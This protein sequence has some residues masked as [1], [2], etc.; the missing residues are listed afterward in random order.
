M[1][2]YGVGTA[3]SGTHSIAALF[4]TNYRARHEADHEE[5]IDV[6][7]R[8]Q[9]G[10]A[11][12]RQVLSELAERERCLSLDADVSQLNMFIVHEL[13]ALSPRARF[14]LTIRD[15]FSW[16]RSFLDHQLR[17]SVDPAW[18]RLRH[19]R[20]GPQRFAYSHHER[21]LEQHGLYAVHSYFRYWRRHNDEILGAVPADRLLV[22]RTSEISRRVGE[23]ARFIGVPVTALDAG[24]AHSFRSPAR[25]SVLA[26]V[27][28]NF[29]R[30]Q[31]LT[32][33]W[34]LMARFFPATMPEESLL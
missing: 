22:V 5:L 23:I 8:K 19:L 12:R 26:Q 27:D 16:L 33:C 28:A 6:I 25:P 9:S 14:I 2:V 18:L 31:M 20:F 34:P 7:L 1:K 13:L 11:P 30:D 32:H 24:K 10:A 29:L 3:K 15:C 21:V 17:F 4:E